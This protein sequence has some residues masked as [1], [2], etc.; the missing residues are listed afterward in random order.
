VAERCAVVAGD[1]FAAVPE[2]D[3]CLLKFVL[4]D[5]DD[6]RACRILQTCR[7]ALPANGRLL[8]VECLLP[9]ANEPGY[10]RYLDL[11]MLVLASG[12]ER[13]E[14]EYAALFETAGFALA[15]TVP[16]RADISVIEG[17]PV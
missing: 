17:R 16:T 10:V 9:P 1:F 8:V 12:R 11:N 7:R 14:E 2:G 4:H 13:S 3:A 6:D 5:W 15:R